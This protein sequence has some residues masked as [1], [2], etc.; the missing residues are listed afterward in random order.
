MN[1][2][3]IV[4]YRRL[5]KKKFLEDVMVVLENEDDS[6][7]D[8]RGVRMLQNLCGYSIKYA[9]FHFAA[10]WNEMKTTTLPN[11]WTKL[12]QDTEPENDF[13]GFETSDFH[14]SIKR[15]HHIQ[16]TLNRP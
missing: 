6:E 7:K 13:K 9:I 4:A 3:V 1:Q 16:L 2:G 14:A 12:L 5:Y 11:G 10:A 15:A 8:T